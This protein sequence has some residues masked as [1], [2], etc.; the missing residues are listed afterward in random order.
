MRT[1]FG[2]IG[3]VMGALAGPAHAQFFEGFDGSFESAWGTFPFPAFSTDDG[4]FVFYDGFPNGVFTTVGGDHVFRMSNEVTDLHYV[5]MSPNAFQLNGTEDIVEAR[6]NTL[7]NSA[8]VSCGPFTMRLVSPGGPKVTVGMFIGNT[9]GERRFR[10]GS[11]V[12]STLNTVGFP[13]LHDAWYRLRF[14]NRGPMLR[15]WI[16]EDDGTPRFSMDFSHTLEEMQALGGGADL[17]LEIVQDGFAPNGT[18]LPRV[19]IDSVRVIEIECFADCDGNGALNVDDI[20]CFVAAFT[21]GSILAADCDGNYALNVDDI[22]CFA[23]S[24]LSACP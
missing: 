14:D 12:D 22:D 2:V 6:I 13:W 16:L 1:R 19:A 17:F 4:P 3:A 18:V 11:T 15:A 9:V 24:F 23:T 10:A 20:D 21:G 8:Q 7:D 5:G